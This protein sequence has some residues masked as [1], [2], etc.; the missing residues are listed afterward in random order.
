LTA[1]AFAVVL[2]LSRNPDRSALK[3]TSRWM[4]VAISSMSPAV[5]MPRSGESMRRMISSISSCS[6]SEM[7]HMFPRCQTSVYLVN[8]VVGGL[9][10]GSWPATACDRRR[11]LCSCNSPRGSVHGTGL[12]GRLWRLGRRPARMKLDRPGSG[13]SPRYVRKP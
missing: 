13:I 1:R 3:R 5:G 10:F 4:R 6:D 9:A 12:R 2:A 8:L 11:G 7:A